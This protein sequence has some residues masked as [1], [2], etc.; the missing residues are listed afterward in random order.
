MEGYIRKIVDR[1][2]RMFGFITGDDMLDYFF[3]PSSIQRTMQYTFGD[4]KI[5]ERVEFTPINGAKPNMWRAI[6]IRRS[7]NGSPDAAA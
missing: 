5:G 6:E 3:L 7:V 1:D 2:G 4:M